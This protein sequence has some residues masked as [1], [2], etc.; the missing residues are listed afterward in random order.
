MRLT[1]SLRAWGTPQFDQALVREVQGL[2]LDALPLQRGLTI[3]SV[4]LDAPRQVM[5]LGTHEDTEAIT[6]RVGVFFGG[7]VGGCSCAD[8]PTPV[9]PTNEYVE[10]SIRIDRATADASVVRE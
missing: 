5:V 10:M 8:D 3:G 7:M 1:D 2:P 6:V 4:V 9:Q